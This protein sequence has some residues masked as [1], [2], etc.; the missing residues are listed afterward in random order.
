VIPSWRNWLNASVLPGSADLSH[1]T[2]R[3]H[4]IANIHEK[5]ALGHHAP[6]VKTQGLLCLGSSHPPP[7]LPQFWPWPTSM[8]LSVLLQFTRSQTVGRTPWT[9]DQLVARPLPVRK[10]RKTHTHTQTPNF[11]ALSWI[12]THDPGFRASEDSACLRLLGYCDRPSH[13]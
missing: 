3:K 2:V 13:P 11:R 1:E 12:R 7:H 6:Y 5:T 9:G 8:K 10:H 4:I